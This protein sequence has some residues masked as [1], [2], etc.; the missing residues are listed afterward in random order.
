LQKI[1]EDSA[2]CFRPE[3]VNLLIEKVLPFF[4]SPIGKL[5]ALSVNAVN[6]ILLVHNESISGVIDPFLQCLFRLA[7][8]DDQVNFFKFT[9]VYCW[10]CFGEVLCSES[11]TLH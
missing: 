8:D 10:V 5:R 4:N 1:C 6:C 7:N 2:A 9:L 3:D 11:L